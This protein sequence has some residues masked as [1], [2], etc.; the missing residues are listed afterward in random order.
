MFI[1]SIRLQPPGAKFTPNI[2]PLIYYNEHAT[3]RPKNMLITGVFCKYNHKSGVIDYALIDISE[4]HLDLIYITIAIYTNHF[5]DII[6][7]CVFHHED[8]I[9]RCT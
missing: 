4:Y 8:N 2:A 9:I 7:N 1:L 5:L 6:N 3:L